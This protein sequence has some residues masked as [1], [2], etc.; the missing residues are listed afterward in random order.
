MALRRR[1]LPKVWFYYKKNLK[2]FFSKIWKKT[3]HQQYIHTLHNI[4]KKFGKS[5]NW[6]KSSLKTFQATHSKEK[7][8]CPIH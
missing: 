3:D 2:I 5:K 8:I 1:S 7:K 6:T 4:L